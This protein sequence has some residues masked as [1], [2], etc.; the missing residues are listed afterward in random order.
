MSFDSIVNGLN[1]V[2]AKSN[3]NSFFVREIETRAGNVI[4]FLRE[5]LKIIVTLGETLINVLGTAVRT[6]LY[7]PR[8]F[9]TIDFLEKLNNAVPGCA[10]ARDSIVRTV[11]LGLGAISTATLGVVVNPNWNYSVH[12]VIGIVP[13][14]PCPV[15]IAARV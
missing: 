1:T 3:S 15:V 4:N 13:R 2:R 7:I 6:V 8:K 12:V 14:Q 9:V 10:Q 11:Q 5:A